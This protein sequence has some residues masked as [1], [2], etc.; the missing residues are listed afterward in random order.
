MTFR[1][2]AVTFDAARVGLR[3]PR[4]DRQQRRFTRPVF[5]DQG[6]ALAV[7]DE[8]LFHIQHHLFPEGFLDMMRFQ[9]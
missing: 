8:Q 5:S 6:N 3:L 2:G 9:K 1:N 7:I 4:E